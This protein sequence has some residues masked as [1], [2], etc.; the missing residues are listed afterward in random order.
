MATE[1]N[2]DCPLATKS[3]RT[4]CPINVWRVVEVTTGGL[5][6][7]IQDVPEH[8]YDEAIKTM[9]DYFVVEEAT[10]KAL[11][12]KHDEDALADFRRLWA[13]LLGLGISVGA[14]KLE[15]GNKLGELVGVNILY[16][17]SV[18]VDK[19]L[20]EMTQKFTSPGSKKLFEFMNSV[21]QKVDIR[22]IY[23]V[24]KYIAGLGCSVKQ[25]FRGHQLGVHLLQARDDIGRKYD[26]TV[27]STAFT[28]PASQKQAERAGYRI[29]FAQDYDKVLDANGEALFP[30]IDAKCLKIMTKVLR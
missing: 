27:S 8:R 14:F 30:N 19:T 5:R 21:S 2:R 24:D 12:L 23:K 16:V 11:D 9:L 4:V 26:I 3:D 15:E 18:E 10:C 17:S 20:E 29:E 1:E 13:Y 6:F 22:K 25:E 7:S 28:G